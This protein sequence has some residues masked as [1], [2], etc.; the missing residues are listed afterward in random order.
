MIAG[1]LLAWSVAALPP[2]LLPGQPFGFIRQQDTDRGIPWVPQEGDVLLMSSKNWSFS[3]MYGFARSGHPYHSAMLVRRATG[4]LMV[5]EVGGGGASSVTARPIPDR[6]L[7]YIEDYIIKK[8]EPIIWVR[9]R[10][11]PLT[12]EQSAKLTRYV[13]ERIGRA[14]T[15]Q[16]QLGGLLLPRPIH[17]A[18]R[19]DER[20]YFCS[21]LVAEALKQT[22]LVEMRES[23][24]TT[25]L[26]PRNLLF[27]RRIDLEGDWSIPLRWTPNSGTPTVRPLLSPR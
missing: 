6:F 15:S 18:T 21:Q 22:G 26:F 24:K 25:S 23:V 17:R 5:F 27:D 13:E 2:V 14:F 20:I 8:H 19:P 11:R 4:E 9:A 16:S 3:I 10:T 1:L 12:P 7:S